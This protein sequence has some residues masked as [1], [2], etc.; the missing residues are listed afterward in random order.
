MRFEV[1][2]PDRDGLWLWK[3]LP[4]GGMGIIRVHGDMVTELS[5]SPPQ[6]HTLGHWW[7]TNPLIETRCVGMD[8]ETTY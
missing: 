2:R 5:V 6:T 8:D 7:E 1:R 4:T 3:S